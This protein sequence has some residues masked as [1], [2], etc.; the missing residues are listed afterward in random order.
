MAQYRVSIDYGYDE[1]LAHIQNR[2]NPLYQLIATQQFDCQQDA[3]EYA[4][5]VSL[6]TGKTVKVK[7]V[8][9]DPHAPLR[10]RIRSL[11]GAE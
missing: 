5:W 1:I 3:E 7:I 8:D 10:E 2:H 11:L 6:Q 4:L 9:P